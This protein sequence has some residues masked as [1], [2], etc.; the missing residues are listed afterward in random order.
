M[1]TFQKLV[2]DV[3]CPLCKWRGFLLLDPLVLQIGCPSRNPGC[4]AEFELRGYTLTYG[5]LLIPFGEGLELE[6]PA[7]NK[8][9]T[10][11]D[12]S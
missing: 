10:N 12:S 11:V 6:F 1:A 3:K 7:L 9:T 5:G 8:E 2:F 4:W